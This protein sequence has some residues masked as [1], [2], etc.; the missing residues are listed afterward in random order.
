MKYRIPLLHLI[1]TCSLTFLLSNPLYSQPPNLTLVKK[2]LIQYHDSGHYQQDLTK[3]IKLARQ[4][5]IQQALVNQH[6]KPQQKL[7]LVLDIDETS[8]SNYEHMVKHNFNGNRF[9]IHKD[10]LAADSPA[11]KPMLALYQDAIKH[12]VS[13]FFITGRSDEDRT[14]TENNLI[15]AGYKN[16]AGL[17]L[18]PNQ[19]TYPSIIPFKSKARAMI[20]QKGYTII[21]SIG[22]QY[23]DIRGGYAKKGFKLPNP[24]YYLP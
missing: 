18:R 11:I 17:Y 21:A 4:Y 3:K 2:E 15:K 7:A 12:G 20:S 19:Y 22:D 1:L 5:I 9:Q 23:S 13:V 10:I 8:L 14:V 24:Y 6:R 16:W